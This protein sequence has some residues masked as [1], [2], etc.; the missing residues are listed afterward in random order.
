MENTTLLGEEIPLVS[1]LRP[2]KEG[3]LEK[4]KSSMEVWMS[5]TPEERRKVRM[6]NYTKERD[7]LLTPSKLTA[8]YTIS[9]FGTD[10]DAIEPFTAELTGIVDKMKEELANEV[11]ILEGTDAPEYK[12]LPQNELSEEKISEEEWKTFLANGSL[13]TVR[14]LTSIPGLSSSSSSVRPNS[15]ASGTP[16]SVGPSFL[17]LTPFSSPIWVVSGCVIDATN[18]SSECTVPMISELTLGTPSE[19]K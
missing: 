5:M 1:S 13:K 2:V 8:A 14:I 12:P 9:N 11:R 7:D 4:F 19:A 15:P 18:E 6:E 16:D 10:L 17:S 3:D